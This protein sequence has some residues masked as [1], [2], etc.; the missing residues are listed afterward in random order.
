VNEQDLLAFWKYDLFPFVLCGT[1]KKFSE[2]V[3]GAV[4]IHGYDGMAFMPI[5]VMPKTVENLAIDRDI[6]ELG[7]EYERA[8]RDLRAEYVQRLLKI[9]PFLKDHV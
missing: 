2:K 7:Q 6:K 3:P 4:A 9:A 5:V 8:Q 1:V